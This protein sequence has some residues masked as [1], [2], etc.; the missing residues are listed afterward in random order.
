MIARPMDPDV[1]PGRAPAPAAAVA[2]GWARGTHGWRRSIVLLGA[3]AAVAF[4]G[5]CGGA[6]SDSP[7]ATPPPVMSATPAPTSPS[8]GGASDARSFATP[9]FASTGPRSDARSWSS[10]PASESPRQSA[11]VRLVSIRSAPNVDNGVRYERLV[12]EFAGGAPGY[13]AQ[14][15]RSVVRPGSGAPL[16]LTGQATFEVVL[17]SATAHD[18]NGTSTLRTPPDGH[19]QSGLTSYAIAGDFEGSVHIGVGLTRVTG[20]RVIELTDPDRLAL[21]FLF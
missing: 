10:Q 12:L 9:T 4:L 5:G 17:T 3:M 20:F 16:P 18:D 14:Y 19:G 1:G 8:P 6:G 15:V 2:N 13:Q 21:D 11:P 7:S